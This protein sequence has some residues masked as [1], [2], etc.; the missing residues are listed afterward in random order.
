MSAVLLSLAVLF[1][2]SLCRVQVVFSM[3][4]ATLVAGLIAGLGLTHT[5]DTFTGGITDNAAIALSYALLGA[6]AAGLTET[7]LPERFVQGAVKLVGSKHASNKA[8]AASRIVLLLAIAGIASLSQNAIPV[9]IAFIP[10]LI[11]P[12]LQLF[13]MMHIDRRA[14]ASAL[15]FGL[16]TPYM[17][18][19]VGFGSIFHETVASNITQNG[20]PVDASILPK[21]MLLPALGMLTGLLISILFTYRK[22]RTY[23]ELPYTSSAASDDRADDAREVPSARMTWTGLLSIAA[24]LALQL[25]TGSMI[26]G[27]AAGLAVL[28]LGRIMPLQRAERV[29]TSGM[30]Q[31]AYIGFVMMSAAGY[32]AVL[33]A[34]GGIESLVQACVGLVGDNRAL[35]AM[36]MLAIGLLVTL[37]IGSSFSTIPIIATVFVPLSLELGFS[38]LAT[39]A[40][41]GTAAALGDAGSPASDSTLGPTS[42]LAADGQHDHIWDTCVP[43]FLHYNIPLLI[44][45]FIAA[46]VL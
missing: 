39:V 21:A 25:S 44:F 35:A 34:T 5:I 20:L 15:T 23:K 16:I 7:G 26:Y 13:N 22:T 9:H 12:L 28:L 10:V 2:L 37:G 4:A 41:I 36:L 18:L 38:T 8:N 17:L 14:V 30:R 19:P 31:M 11:P 6:Y 32:A 46:M 45:G 33:R 40:L 1:I 29:F 3:L 27:A 43:T 42:G 24:M